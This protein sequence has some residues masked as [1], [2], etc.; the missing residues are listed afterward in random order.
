MG[1][2][3][4]SENSELRERARQALASRL[5]HDSSRDRLTQLGADFVFSFLRGVVSSSRGAVPSAVDLD[6]LI[7]R[8]RQSNDTRTT[9][10]FLE[11]VLKEVKGRLPKEEDRSD[12]T[13]LTSI[14]LAGLGY[15]IE[16]AAR[17]AG[18]RGRLA[19]HTDRLLNAIKDRTRKVDEFRKGL[20]SR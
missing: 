9:I 4:L 18:S 17:D 6:Y 14:S 13:G 20:L 5:E 11:D 19:R 10:G 16:S 8:L 15:L 12:E 1:S 2:T 7:A 3:S